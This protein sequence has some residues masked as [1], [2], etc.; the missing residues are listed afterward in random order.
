MISKLIVSMFSI[1][2][3]VTLSGCS[4]SATTPADGIIQ[5]ITN[6]PVVTPTSP[7]QT[8]PTKTIGLKMGSNSI[9]VSSFADDVQTFYFNFNSITAAKID[10]YNESTMAACPNDPVRTVT[11][12]DFESGSEKNIQTLGDSSIFEKPASSKAYLKIV[13]S[14]LSGCMAYGSTFRFDRG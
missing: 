2:L 12:V 7:A 9:P 11:L 4:V 8:E 5:P 1:V 14:G 13:I 6:P 3:F 10:Y